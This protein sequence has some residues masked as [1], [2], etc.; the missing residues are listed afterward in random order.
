LNQKKEKKYKK[1]LIKILKNLKN[2]LILKHGILQ[3]L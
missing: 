2:K 3:E 1:K